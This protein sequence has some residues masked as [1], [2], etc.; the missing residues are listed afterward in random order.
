M[1]VVAVGGPHSI[2]TL[3]A[4]AEAQPLHPAGDAIAAM[5]V[6]Q[7][8]EITNNPGRSI[9]LTALCVNP[10]DLLGQ[11]LILKGL[12]TGQGPTTLPVGE[13]TGGNLDQATQHGDRV[14]ASQ[15][16]NPFEALDGGSE[17]MPN[18]LLECPVAPA[19]AGSRAGQPPA[20]PGY[21]G[22]QTDFHESKPSH[23]LRPVAAV[24][25]TKRA[26]P[27]SVPVTGLPPL[28]SSHWP[29]SC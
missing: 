15:C 21:W 19:D 14:L 5:S 4:F 26:A 29:A 2:P 22:S 7:L 13:T 27:G 23:P 11:S 16:M 8:L 28:P 1:I 3:L 9:S 20:G 24:D 17:R 25:A 10:R 12:G 18:V 6:S